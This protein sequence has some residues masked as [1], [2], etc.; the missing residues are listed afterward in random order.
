MWRKPSA[1]SNSKKLAAPQDAISSYYI[2]GYYTRNL[3]RDGKSRKIAV[4]LKE[5]TTAKLNSRLGYYA[6]NSDD[7]FSGIGNG[8]VDP[9]ITY[10]VLIQKL[11]AGYSEKARKAKLQGHVILYVE[12]DASGQ[13]TNPKVIRS[14]GLGLDEKAIEAVMQWKFKP[15]MKDGKPVA[16]QVEVSLSFMLL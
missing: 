4:A 13:V 9:G 14:L 7:G 8:S 3:T 15:A 5:D 6:P 2:L 11:E 16:V 1:S 12:V 10:P